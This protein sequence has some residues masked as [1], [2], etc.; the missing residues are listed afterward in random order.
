MPQGSLLDATI[1]SIFP[2]LDTDLAPIFVDSVILVQNQP[3]SIDGRYL[4][5][6]IVVPYPRQVIGVQDCESFPMP[7]QFA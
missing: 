5:I 7:G 1:Y 4:W 2:W 6:E 3:K